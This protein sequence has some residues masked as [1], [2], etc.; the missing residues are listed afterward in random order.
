VT[1]RSLTGFE[2]VLLGLLVYEPRSGY[3]L[4]K[5][6]TA[7][8]AA[9]YQPS[10]GA[11]Y[12]ALRRLE[13]RGL[14]Y[15]QV[16]VSAG[17]RGR[18]IWHPTL[19]G[20]AMHLDWVRQPVRPESVAADLGL[21]LMRFVMMERQLPAEEVSAFLTGLID[22]LEAFVKGIEGYVASAGDSLPGRHPRLAL[23]HGIEVHR[24]SLNWARSALRELDGANDTP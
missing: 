23:L 6:F 7:T 19:A 24:A 15:T 1:E 20:R 22:A 21:H 12:P 3:D 2:Q 17:R 9:V 13:R 11:L 16:T 4:K 18:R 14:L 8:P 5:L 10:A